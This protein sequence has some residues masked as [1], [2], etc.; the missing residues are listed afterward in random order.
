LLL[1]KLQEGDLTQG[2]SLGRNIDEIKK[3]L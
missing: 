1:K 2:N 3:V